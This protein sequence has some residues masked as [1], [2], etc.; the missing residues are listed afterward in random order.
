MKNLMFR[1]PMPI[2]LVVAMLWMAPTGASAQQSTAAQQYGCA[3][4]RPILGGACPWC[5]W[6]A[7]TR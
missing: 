2:L 7:P 1:K 4:K 3:V 5:P 6:G